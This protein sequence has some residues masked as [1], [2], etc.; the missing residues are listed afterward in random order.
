M[1]AEMLPIE[2]VG[3][4]KNLQDTIQILRQLGCVHIDEITESMGISAR[5][6]TLD[7]STLPTVDTERIAAPLSTARRDSLLSV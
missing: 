1:N 3:L 2:I 5:P 7:P 6:L 4:K